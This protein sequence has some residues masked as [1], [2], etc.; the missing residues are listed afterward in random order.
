MEQLRS[1]RKD[2][3]DILYLSTFRK[4]VEKIHVSLKSG[5]SKTN[6][7][8][9]SYVAQF[10]LKWEMLHTNVVEKLKTHIL[11]SVNFS[12]ILQ[13]MTK[14]EKYCTVG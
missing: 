5:N 6:A 3:H 10:L 11:C 1:Y 7:H 9:L 14:C 13:F 4:P 2:F 8:V 12:K